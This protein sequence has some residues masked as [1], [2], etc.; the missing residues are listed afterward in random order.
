MLNFAALEQAPV[1]V[2]PFPFVAVPNFIDENALELIEKDYPAVS[3]PGSF[4]LETP[5]LGPFAF[6]PG[7]KARSSLGK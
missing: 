3:K 2:N 7:C 6:R 5:R 1:H 4:P